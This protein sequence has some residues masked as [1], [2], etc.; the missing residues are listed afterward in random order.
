MKF[1][2]KTPHLSESSRNNRSLDFLIIPIAGDVASLKVTAA[3][4][5]WSFTF[6]VIRY[7][8]LRRAFQAKNYK[9][10]YGFFD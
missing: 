10:L 9:I 6:N 1:Y 3:A 4:G 2:T 7:I 8:V 5:R